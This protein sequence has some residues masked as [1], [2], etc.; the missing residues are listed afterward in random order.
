MKNW[1]LVLAILTA[2]ARPASAQQASAVS[3]Y[4]ALHPATNVELTVYVIS[5]M[6]QAPAGAK[7]DVP[8]D[9]VSTLQQMHGVLTYK[10]YKLIE[11]VALRGRNNSGAEVAGQLPDY[12]YYTFKYGRARVSPETPRIIHLD[13][14]RLEITRRHADRLDPVALVATDLD[15]KEGQKTVVGKSAVNGTDAFFIVIV[16]KVVE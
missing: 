5:G 14:L 16:P 12:S 1:L 13:A 8:Q 10:S 7:D 3:P 6:A 15:V 2:P 11:A 4:S 9:L